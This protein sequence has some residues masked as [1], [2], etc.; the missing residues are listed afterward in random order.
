MSLIDDLSTLDMSNPGLWPLPVK[1]MGF[2]S[3][4]VLVLV[5]AWYL[6]IVGMREE[7]VRLQEEEI[8]HL[9]DME[10]KQRK[11]ANLGPLKE[12]MAEMEQSFGEMVRQLPDRTAV[13][14]LLVDISQTGLSAGLEFKLFKPEAAVPS[15]FYSTLPIQIHVYGS[16]HEMGQFV[17][18]LAALPRIVT[19]HDM[20]ISS[21]E[22]DLEKLLLT[23]VARTYQSVD[24]QADGDIGSDIGDGI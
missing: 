4:F 10:E 24:N 22:G 2:A 15:E 12:Q 11:A 3:V 17:S 14:S 19:V 7:L 9:K 18:G 21:A 20:K 5:L 23:T 8:S 6:D 16:Y 1:S 13:E